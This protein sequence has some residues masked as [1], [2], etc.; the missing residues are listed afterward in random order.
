MPIISPGGI[1]GA[2]LG[3]PTTAKWPDKG[4]NVGHC[5]FNIFPLTSHYGEIDFSLLFIKED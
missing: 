3:D 4:F 1:A 2:V 5:N